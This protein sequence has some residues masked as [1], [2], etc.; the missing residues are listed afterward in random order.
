MA[1]AKSRVPVTSSRSPIRLMQSPVAEEALR[2]ALATGR[3]ILKFISRNDVGETGGHQYG[4]YLPK[5]LW[6]L[7]TTMPPKR[8][9]VTKS[10][11]TVHWSNGRTTAQQS[12]GMAP[13]PE[14]S[15]V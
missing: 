15:I 7:F 2:D 14:A 12:L 6:E 13:E 3:A 5:H 9:S 1:F 8:G 4:F 10:A 11:V